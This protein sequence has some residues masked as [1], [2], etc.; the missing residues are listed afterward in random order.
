MVHHDTAGAILLL[1]SLRSCF[2]KAVQADALP[3][4]EEV[5]DYKDARYASEF[6][7]KN[8]MIPTHFRSG[9][10]LSTILDAVPDMD[11]KLNF[12]QVV[13]IPYR[14]GR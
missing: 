9:T 11:S 12:P 10:R 1:L 3:I 13:G 2:N 7:Y 8:P 4:V 6:V 14:V 5:R